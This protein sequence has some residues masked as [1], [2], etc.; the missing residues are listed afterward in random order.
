M[1]DLTVT[2][3][4]EPCITLDLNLTWLHLAGD[5]HLTNEVRGVLIYKTL[6]GHKMGFISHSI[7]ILYRVPFVFDWTASA[8]S[9]IVTL[10][11]MHED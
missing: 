4:N 10:E 8:H 1:G 9:I 6:T 5:F 7:H 2:Q 11:C 3:I